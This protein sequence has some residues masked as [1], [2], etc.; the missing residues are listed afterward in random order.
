[1]LLWTFHI[2]VAKK[3]NKK[4]VYSLVPLLLYFFNLFNA[5]WNLYLQIYPWNFFQFVPSASVV[6]F[7]FRPIM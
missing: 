1:M 7:F 6:L 3:R 4:V 5:K 2:L